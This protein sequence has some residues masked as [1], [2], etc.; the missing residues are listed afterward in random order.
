LVQPI[1]F[2]KSVK[3]HPLEIFVII[4]AGANIG[5]IAGMVCAIP[6]YTIIKV[7]I[8]ELGFGYSQYHIFK[9]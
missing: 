1:I 3:A 8:V 5:G 6:F 7:A 2:S 9:N 4:F